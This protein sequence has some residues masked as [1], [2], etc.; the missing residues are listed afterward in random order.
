M[1]LGDKASNQAE[2][3]KGQVKE[4]FGKATGNEQM[5]ADGKLDQAKANAKQ[6]VE[7]AKDGIADAFNDATDGK[8]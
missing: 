1:G 7:S 6:G 5:E 3:S 8:K 2:E 4:G